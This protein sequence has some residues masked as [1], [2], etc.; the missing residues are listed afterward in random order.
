MVKKKLKIAITGNIGSGKSEFAR[1]IKNKNY[2]VI[3]ADDL[4]KSI[5]END[6]LI[7]KEV[8]KLLGKESFRD[9]KPNRKYLADLVFN[10]PEKLKL[11]E[12]ILHPAVIKKTNELMELAL[13]QNDIV[14]TE[15]ALIYEADMEKY[16]DFVVLIAADK[17]LRFNRKVKPGKLSKEEFEKRDSLQIDQDEKRKRAD[18]IFENNSDLEQLERKAGLLFILINHPGL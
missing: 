11:L 7:K 1:F 8:I 16:F 4:S 17:K 13:K 3:N 14:F 15:A 9:G 12:K 2:I 5:L 6:P 18:F 10:D